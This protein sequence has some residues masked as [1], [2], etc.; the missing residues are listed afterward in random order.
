[1][2]IASTTL[3]ATIAAVI[4]AAA[5]ASAAAAAAARTIAAADAAGVNHE[6]QRLSTWLSERWVD[7]RMVV[8]ASSSSSFSYTARNE[9][10]PSSSTA[11]AS[12]N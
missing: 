5:A 3:F 8:L 12:L 9:L 10:E 4:E 1:M 2:S 7:G 6:L 11:S